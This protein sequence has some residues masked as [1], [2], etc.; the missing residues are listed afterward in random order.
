[1]F[2]LGELAE[3][4]VTMKFL[5]VSSEKTSCC[6]FLAVSHSLPLHLSWCW[7][8]LSVAAPALLQQDT[9][10][11][12]CPLPLTFLS[13]SSSSRMQVCQRHLVRVC[14]LSAIRGQLLFPGL[15]LRSPLK[16]NLGILSRS[17]G[18]KQGCFPN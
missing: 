14:L 5:G 6:G 10:W 16:C 13:M 9:L 8:V 17:V 7:E 2:L 15:L 12:H 18:P 4:G 1:M 3:V 11:S